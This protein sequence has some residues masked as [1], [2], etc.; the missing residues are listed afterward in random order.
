MVFVGYGVT[1]PE[2]HYDDYAGV[3]VKGKIVVIVANAPPKD[4]TLGTLWWDSVGGALYVWRGAWIGLT[5]KEHST[6][7]KQRLV[8]ISRAGN[9]RLRSLLVVC[10]TSVIKAA[11][12]PASKQRT[13]WLR[14]LLQRKPRKVAAVALANK[15]AR[16]AWAVMTYG[17]VYRR[18]PT[19]SEVSHAA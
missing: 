16:V 4:P 12:M 5:P 15:I 6:G 19:I 8:G 3:D 11:T 10:A 14:G 2:R 18:S 13:G 9:E 17:T 7:G 1:A